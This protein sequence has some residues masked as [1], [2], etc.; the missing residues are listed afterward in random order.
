MTERPTKRRHIAPAETRRKL[1]DATVACLVA[2]GY[3]GTTT[4]RVQTAAGVSRGAL[5][6]HFPTKPD[7]FVGAI[8]Y[9]AE[10][11]AAQLRELAERLP[12]AV[13]DPAGT[14]RI[15]KAVGA[16]RQAMSGATFLAGV[17][18]WLAARTDESLRATLMPAERQV[19]KELG[20]IAR[21]LF[22]EPYASGPGFEI[23]FDSLLQLLRG[24][25]LT[26]VLRTNP[27]T[28][29]QVIDAW[30]TVFPALC[31]RTP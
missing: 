29:E 28:E 10:V 9:V 15:T 14:D 21:L 25:A 7:L 6:H 2:F 5:L 26:G 1:I 22:G 23:A 17:E 30:I 20:D 3:S 24:L 8:H 4:Q 19:G 16:V 18:L 13:P 12:G 27:H 31:A 11:Q